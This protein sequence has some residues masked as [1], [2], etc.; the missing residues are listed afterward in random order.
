MLHIHDFTFNSIVYV[1]IFNDKTQVTVHSDVVQQNKPD[2]TRMFTFFKHR[3]PCNDLLFGYSSLIDT[4]VDGKSL[5]KD[6]N[7]T[8]NICN[9][10][11]AF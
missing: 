2:Q 6:D 5:I 8:H 9:L 3:Q 4:I 1:R 11:V 10:Q 7:K